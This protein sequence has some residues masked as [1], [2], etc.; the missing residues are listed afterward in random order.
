MYNN[1][2]VL[3]LKEHLMKI[4]HHHNRTGKNVIAAFRFLHQHK[5]LVR[6]K[7]V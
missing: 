1:K 4:N 7:T 5:N 2:S 6:Y 3:K